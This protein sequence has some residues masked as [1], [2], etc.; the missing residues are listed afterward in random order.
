[1][2][3]CRLLLEFPGRALPARYTPFVHFIVVTI[4]LI[5]N[6]PP[7]LAGFVK[8]ESIAKPMGMSPGCL[9]TYSKN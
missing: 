5:V 8:F 4:Y 2:Q 9:G 3:D 7:I 6:Q 1:L